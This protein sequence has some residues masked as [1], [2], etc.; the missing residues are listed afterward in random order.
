MLFS[1]FC[2]SLLFQCKCA[3]SHWWT[4]SRNFL[5]LLTVGFLISVNSPFF[6]TPHMC[7]KSKKIKRFC[8][9]SIFRFA[10]DSKPAKLYYPRLLFRQLQ[11]EFLH[12]V[13]RVSCK[14]LLSLACIESM[15]DNHRQNVSDTLPH[16]RS[17]PTLR[18]LSARLPSRLPLACGWSVKAR[19][20]RLSEDRDGSPRFRGISISVVP[21]S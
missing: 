12:P 17:F 5:Q 14:F 3:F 13:L 21:C 7:L 10:F 20:L 19:V 15:P 16:V 8:F 1:C 11:S 2:W 9:L 6:P 18:V 4:L